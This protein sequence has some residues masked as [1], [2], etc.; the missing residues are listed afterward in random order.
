M[1]PDNQTWTAR[2]LDADMP[3]Y[4]M[5]IV[6]FSYIFKKR[7]SDLKTSQSSIS[8]PIINYSVIAAK[9]FAH[10]LCLCLLSV[11]LSNFF[12]QNFQIFYTLGISVV[13][14]VIIALISAKSA[15]LCLIKLYQ[16]RAP[17]EIRAKCV[18]SP[19]CSEYMAGAIEK[20]GLYSGVSRGFH[21]LR[22]CAPPARFD[23]P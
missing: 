14:L 15:V 1:A 3:N 7:P 22:R 11:T 18:M 9:I 16:A 17:S 12:D 20:Y 21:R 23:Y 4:R 2:G 6:L 8:R 19:S 13:Y 10:F 5:A